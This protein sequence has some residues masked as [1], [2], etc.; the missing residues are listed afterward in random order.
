[1]IK[2]VILI[3]SLVANLV[4][5]IFLIGL[6]PKA[7]EE[8]HFSYV[9]RDTI[10]PNTIRNYLDWENYGVAASLSRPIRGGAQVFE[11]DADYYKLGEYAELLFL[12]KVFAA[13]QNTDTAEKCESRMTQIRSEMPSYDTVFDKIDQSCPGQQ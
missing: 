12:S 2:K 8:L 7:I 4:L 13:A 9:E 10:L 6:L 3:L 5:A 1:M 11:E